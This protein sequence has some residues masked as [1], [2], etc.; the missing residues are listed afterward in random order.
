VLNVTY[1]RSDFMPIAS[2]EDGELTMSMFSHL[3]TRPFLG[4]RADF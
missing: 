3:P 2:V 4:V 1:A